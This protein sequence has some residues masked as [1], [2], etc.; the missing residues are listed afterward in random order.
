[1][2]GWD[3]LNTCL[4]VYSKDLKAPHER[5]NQQRGEVWHHVTMV[6]L[7]LDDSKTNDDGDGKENGKE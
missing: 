3:S 2:P 7:V 1:M 4:H 5:G 6:A